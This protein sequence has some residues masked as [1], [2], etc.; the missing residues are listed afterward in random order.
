MP[1]TAVD[2]LAEKK[3]LH[4]RRAYE[5]PLQSLG[6]HQLRGLAVP[7]ELFAPTPSQVKAA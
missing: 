1:D 2:L 3:A 7:H 6:L 4:R 5:A